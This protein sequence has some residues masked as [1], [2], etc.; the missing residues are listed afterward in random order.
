MSFTKN[1]RY[2]RIESESGHEYLIDFDGKRTFDKYSNDGFIKCKLFHGNGFSLFTPDQIYIEDKKLRWIQPLYYSANLISKT[3][4]FIECKLWVDISF[5]V[6]LEITFRNSDHVI[7]LSDGSELYKCKILGPENLT[8]YSTGLARWKENGVPQVQLFHHTKKE[9]INKIIKSG[10]FLPSSWN[11]Q[12][13]K[14]LSNIKYV[15]FTCLNKILFEDDLQQIA[16]SNHGQMG[17]RL[18]QN[19]SDEPDLILDVYRENTLNRD[20]SIS[21]WIDSSFLTSQPVFKHSPPGDSV[22]YAI[23]QPFT[24]RVGLKPDTVLKITDEQVEATD[25]RQ[26]GYIV[27]GDATTREGL[28]APFDEEETEQILKIEEQSCSKNNLE[29][30]MERSNKNHFGK[31]STETIEFES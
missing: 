27:I 19:S 24:H 20:N 31:I 1:Y 21:K 29:F 13:N 6:C 22:Y 9:T 16:M 30:W 14:K 4:T 12:G 23:V 26:L 7:T 11:I 5:G 18:D 28:V 8:K 2:N 10:Y 15:Y 3:D 17:F 25:I